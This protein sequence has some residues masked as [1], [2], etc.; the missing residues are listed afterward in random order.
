[1]AFPT[2]L[3]GA[4]RLALLEMQRQFVDTLVSWGLRP[5]GSA[6]EAATAI[7]EL[8]GLLCEL[9]NLQ[10]PLQEVTGAWIASLQAQGILRPDSNV[11]SEQLTWTRAVARELVAFS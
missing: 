11:D 1:M 4:V 10:I 3:A 2:A 9:A 5:R 8:C 6:E 7:S